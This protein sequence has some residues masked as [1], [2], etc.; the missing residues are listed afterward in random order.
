MVVTYSTYVH[1]LP[2]YLFPTY[3]YLSFESKHGNVDL[4]NAHG[5][6]RTRN[7]VNL[8]DQYVDQYVT[9]QAN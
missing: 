3:D 6:N 9:Y 1:L 2:A 7:R 8:I 4:P 5:G